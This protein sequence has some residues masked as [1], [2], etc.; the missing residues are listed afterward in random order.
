MKRLALLR[1]ATLPFGALAPLSGGDAA[2]RA[3]VFLNATGCADRTAAA[4]S[5]AL[6]AAAGPPPDDPARSRARFALLRVRRDVHA[7]RPPRTTDLV[8]AEPFLDHEITANLRA[9][10]RELTARAAASAAFESS[11]K[12]AMEDGHRGLLALAATPLVEHGMYLASRS[13]VPKVR[14]LARRD[15]AAW[16]HVERHTAAKAAAYVARFTTKTSPNGVFCAVAPAWING[17]EAVV[18][19]T[20]GVAHTDV[21]LSLAEVRKA[22]ACLAVD[23]AIAPVIVPRP[24]P[25]LREWNG[26]WTWWRA[27]SPRHPTDEETHMQAKDH[28]LL[29]AFVESCACESLATDALVSAVAGRT[30]IDEASLHTFLARLVERGILIAELEVPWSSRRRFRDLASDVA[31]RGGRATWNDALEQIESAVDRLPDLPFEARPAA[32]EAI[33]REV[34]AL[35]RQ[36]PFR[37]DEL[38]RVDSASAFDVRLPSSVLD[39]LRSAMSSFTALLASSYPER[40]QHRQLVRRF[41]AQHPPD[42]DV[43]FLDLYGTLSEPGD[44]M[45]APPIELPEPPT[46]AGEARLV[47]E[48]LVRQAIG[49]PPIEEIELDLGRG[50]DEPRW[51]AGVL[52]QVAAHSAADLGSG[53]Y[54]I[55]ITGIFNGV[56]LALSRFAHLLQAGAPDGAVVDELRRSWS[57]VEKPDAVLAELTFNHEARTA[58]AGL[59]P[60][61]FPREIELPGDLATPA[62]ERFPLVDLVLRY[63]AATDR[64]VLRS[65]SR[66]IEVVPVLGS[67]VSPSGIVSTLIHIGRQGF[68]TVGYLPGFH[69]PGITRWP[70]ITIGRVVLFRER[71]LFGREAMPSATSGDSAF[72]LEVE[73]WRE[74]HELPRHVFVHTSV[75]PK[76]FYVDLESPV[77]VDLVRRAIAAIGETDAALLVVTEML[78][79]P[80]ELWVRDEAGAY[81]SEFLVQMEGPAAACRSSS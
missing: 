12:S 63:D 46:S 39:D 66:G 54:R 36:R 69:A 59:R 57:F 14:R 6:F 80:D 77:L 25:T 60:V 41:L 73:R 32:M 20:G 31:R 3:N 23:P 8:E 68:Q 42:T 2:S 18:R 40:A 70:R 17:S 29:R 28:P 1:V 45:T 26:G 50:L 38:F 51:S 16:A 35:P 78:P 62:V 13:L 75:E 34:E 72:F 15:P 58:N 9:C 30:G 65:L 27:A 79:G 47:Y 49:T 56:G 55:A 5:D 37:A 44:A 74:A 67:G 76:P 10:D 71:W 24:N 21:L 43:P 52:F 53:R 48:R 22:A 33:A 4:T 64:L 7:Q 81:A 61:L 19:G 11:W